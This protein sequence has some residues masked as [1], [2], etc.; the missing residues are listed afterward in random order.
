ASEQY[1]AVLTWFRSNFNSEEVSLVALQNHLAE[2]DSSIREYFDKI[3]AFRSEQ[4][5]LQLEL[6]S[7][8]QEAEKERLKNLKDERE[9]ADGKMD[10]FRSLL[11]DK[12]EIESQFIDQ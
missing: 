6:S 12:L 5:T 2:N 8:N 10:G 7:F 4:Q 1:L 11:K 3:A 9:D